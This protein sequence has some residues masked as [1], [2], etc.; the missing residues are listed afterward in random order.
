MKWSHLDAH[1]VCSLSGMDFSVPVDLRVV[2]GVAFVDD[3]EMLNGVLDDQTNDVATMIVDLVDRSLE[4][5]PNV[6]VE[7]LYYHRCFVV[8]ER[9]CLSPPS[10][11]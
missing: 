4:P 5:T 1:L 10:I 2:C 9:F 6:I 8:L 11:I 7:E 3:S